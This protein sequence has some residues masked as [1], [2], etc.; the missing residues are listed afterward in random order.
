MPSHPKAARRVLCVV[1][2][3][4]RGAREC[5]LRLAARHV[6]VTY[7][8]KG[9]LPPALRELIPLA[10]GM[11]LITVPRPL[12]RLRLWV[13]L[14]WQGAWRRVGWIVVDHER[15]WQEVAT[16][17]RRVGVVPVMSRETPEACE[18][19]QHDHPASFDAVFV[20]VADAHRADLR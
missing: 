6:P 15:T 12:F 14:L 8:I 13:L 4:W 11:R 19:W 17:C 20:G 7:L 2:R 3:G 10:P 16:W 9:W 1:E 18:L 5:S